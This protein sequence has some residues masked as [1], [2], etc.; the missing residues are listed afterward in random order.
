MKKRRNE[1][2]DG[3]GKTPRKPAGNRTMFQTT[4]TNIHTA[5]AFP[6]ARFPAESGSYPRRHSNPV[7]RYGRR[8]NLRI[9]FVRYSCYKVHLPLQPATTQ[10]HR[11]TII[12][13]ASFS[14]AEE[15]YGPFRF[16]S[17]KLSKHVRKTHF[18]D[19]GAHLGISSVYLTAEHG[20]VPYR[21]DRI[22]QLIC[23]DLER[24][25]EKQSSDT[26]K[27]PYDRMKRC[28]ERK[29][30]IKASER[31]NVDVFT[32][33][34][35]PCASRG[36]AE[37]TRD[38]ERD[39][40]TCKHTERDRFVYPP[41]II[42][43][44][45][46]ARRAAMFPRPQ[47]KH[48][49]LSVLARRPV[50]SR[51]PALLLHCPGSVSVAPRRRRRVGQRKLTLA[52]PYGGHTS[53]VGKQRYF[54]TNTFFL[55]NLGLYCWRLGSWRHGYRRHK[56]WRRG[57]GCGRRILACTAG[58]TSTGA[59]ER[60]AAGESWPVLLAPRL[61]APQ[62]LA[63]WRRMRPANLG[64]YCLR[65]GYRRHKYWRRGA[66]CG[67]RF[68]ACIAGVMA[69]GATSTGAVEPDAAGESWPVLLAPRLQA[70]Q[71]LAPWSG[72]RPAILGLYCWRHGYR[73][74]KYWRRGDGCG[75]RILACTACATATGATSTGA[76]ERDAAGDSWPVLLASW[77]QAPQVLAPWSGMRPAN[78]GLYCWRHGYRRHKY[79][80]RG[81]G[82]GRRILTCTA[83]A[84]ATGA[85]STGAVER[86]AAGDSSPVLLASWLQAP[87]VLAPWS[88]MRPANLG[89]YCW[90]HGYRRH[91]Y[92]RRGAG[93]GLRI[94]ACTA[95]ATATG[96]TS[97]GAVERD[98]AGESWPVL[99][100]PRVLAPKLLARVSAE[101]L[102]EARYRSQ[103]CT[104]VQFFARRGDE[105]VDAHVSV[106]PSAPTLLV[107]RRAKFLQPVGY[108]N[109]V[110]H[111]PDRAVCIRS[112][113]SMWALTS[114][115]REP[116][117]WRRVEYGAA[118]E[119]KSTGEWHQPTRFSH[120]S[121][122]A[123]NRTR[124]ALAR[125]TDKPNKVD[126]CEEFPRV[127]T[128]DAP[129]VT[130]QPWWLSPGPSS[131]M[132]VTKKRRTR[133]CYAQPC[134]PRI[135]RLHPSLPEPFPASGSCLTVDSLSGRLP[136]RHTTSE[137]QELGVPGAPSRD[138][139]PPP[140]YQRSQPPL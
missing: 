46:P 86:D 53:Y 8:L 95:G 98:T 97:T 100:V 117:R 107:L 66:G 118:P 131:P 5:E 109:A 125:K 130:C 92:W 62:V 45:R 26:H 50:I 2:A 21:N 32:Q 40:R 16:S 56:Y 22:Q 44:V 7:R 31:V 123:G 29:I 64:L 84:T 54:T 94:L 3:N 11:S 126:R 139:T 48:P 129:S 20:E 17:E 119:C 140:L 127:N 61:Q 39:P 19:T 115:S 81:A 120:V 103:D 116:V 37:F 34:K 52:V 80:R 134:P 104:P 137:V 73:R 101:S 42:N 38:L 128:A 47:I 112:P 28:R 63:P 138:H 87:Q 72:M 82:C 12:T 55:R 135:L 10:C 85:T 74:H 15:H 67:R 23:E 132:R 99:L 68:L 111:H 113:Y 69:T 59:V 96:A 24:V 58:A 93:C 65:H 110:R 121:D 136:L 1:R 105:R 124:F 122:P 35:R 91:K 6:V 70:P 27:T 33:N 14:R 60:D 41:V 4:A 89:L 75:R 36:S 88:G 49:Y 133:P 71:V 83:C 79:W 13:Q 18:I 25:F 57:A 114:R 51:W 108:L 90:R 9:P 106:A 30:N 77:L 102:I 76:V 78:L 43:P